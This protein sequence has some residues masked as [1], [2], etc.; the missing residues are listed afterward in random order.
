MLP[1]LMNYTNVWP[2][3]FVKLEIIYLHMPHKL[4][5]ISKMMLPTFGTASKGC[6]SPL[7]VPTISSQSAGSVEF[8]IVLRGF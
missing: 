8:S 2:L 7:D 5:G 1:R 3:L 4:L 6:P